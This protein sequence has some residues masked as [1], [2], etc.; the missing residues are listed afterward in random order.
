MWTIKSSNYNQNLE[1]YINILKIHESKSILK[2]HF[3]ARL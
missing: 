1:D 3:L 2:M